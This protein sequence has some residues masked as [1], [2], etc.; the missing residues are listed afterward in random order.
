[1]ASPIAYKNKKL[2]Q[3]RKELEKNWKIFENLDCKT[4]FEKNWDFF[5]NTCNQSEEEFLKLFCCNVD[6]ISF[7]CLNENIIKKNSTRISS[8]PKMST[9]V[10]IEPKKNIFNNNN[11]QKI[12]IKQIKRNNQLKKSKQS[13]NKIISQK[14]NKKIN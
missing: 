13:R 9:G 8:I 7:K 12:Q 4:N 14:R 2:E 1:M 5:V 11:I 6:P 10:R 3:T